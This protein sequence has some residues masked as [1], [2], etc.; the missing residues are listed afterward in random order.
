MLN[1][2]NFLLAKID[3]THD[4]INRIMNN[5]I[6]T[7]E[8]LLL[9]LLNKIRFAAERSIDRIWANRLKKFQNY[10][11]ATKLRLNSLQSLKNDAAV[12]YNGGPPGIRLGI[13]RGNNEQYS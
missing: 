6:K 1:N 12:Y 13:K 11:D 8:D 2:L 9:F 3:E 7:I 5:I 10:E 4:I